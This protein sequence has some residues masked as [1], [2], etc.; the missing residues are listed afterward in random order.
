MENVEKE[1]DRH[2]GIRSKMWNNDCP[3]ENVSSIKIIID[4]IT[5][6]ENYYNWRG[7]KVDG[8]ISPKTKIQLAKKIQDLIEEKGEKYSKYHYRNWLLCYL[9]KFLLFFSRYL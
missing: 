3:T 1:K 5:V 6:E 4:W 9:F 8:R 2:N 7:G